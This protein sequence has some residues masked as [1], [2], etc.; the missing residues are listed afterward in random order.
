MRNGY[1]QNE[2]VKRYASGQAP[3]KMKSVCTKNCAE[4]TTAHLYEMRELRK[5]QRRQ[6]TIERCKV[7]YNNNK[8]SQ[9]APS[10]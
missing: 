6:A 7:K 3:C 5:Y 8:D 4:C 10:S 2:Q 1:T 9:N